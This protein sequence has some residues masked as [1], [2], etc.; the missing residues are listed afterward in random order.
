MKVA[1]SGESIQYTQAVEV[2][3][4]PEPVRGCLNWQPGIPFESGTYQ[5]EI[6]NKGFLSGKGSFALK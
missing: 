5:V 6:Y 1:N 4:G 3:Y 2:D